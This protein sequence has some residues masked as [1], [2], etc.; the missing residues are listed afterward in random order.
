MQQ[1]QVCLE[2]VR[3]GLFRHDLAEQP[4]DGLEQH[5]AIAVG[6]GRAVPV[7]RLGDRGKARRDF[8]EG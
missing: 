8:R 2:R 7:Q 6:G 5:E 3:A 4:P 1:Q